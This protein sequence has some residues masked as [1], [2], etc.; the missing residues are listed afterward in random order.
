MRITAPASGIK[1]PWTPGVDHGC[2][3][4]AVR[5]RLGL[6]VRRARCALASSP[7]IRH[8]RA[9][10]HALWSS[11][12]SIWPPPHPHQPRRHSPH[13]IRTT[14]SG[15]DHSRINKPSTTC[16]QAQQHTSPILEMQATSARTFRR[17]HPTH[18]RAPLRHE[19]R[20]P[21]TMGAC[22][23]TR[24]KTCMA[25]TARSWPT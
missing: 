18:F 9:A 7:E 10:Q 5:A 8:G 16:T 15:P 3:L 20:D 13:R 14:P 23:M 4:P 19:G 17:C 11:P 1:V 6:P 2:H 22:R 21:E 24:V 25:R 12:H